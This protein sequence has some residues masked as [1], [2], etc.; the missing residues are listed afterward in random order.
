MNSEKR[1]YVWNIHFHGI[2]LTTIAYDLFKS[3]SK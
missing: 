1:E 3:I 2:E